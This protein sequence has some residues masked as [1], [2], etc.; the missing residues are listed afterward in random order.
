MNIIVWL[1]FKLTTARTPSQYEFAFY[2]FVQVLYLYTFMFFFHSA[3]SNYVIV[4]IVFFSF[5]I[6]IEM[7]IC[8]PEMQ[9]QI[10]LHGRTLDQTPSSSFFLN[11]ILMH[12][13]NKTQGLAVI[14]L[15]LVRQSNSLLLL[16]NSKFSLSTYLNG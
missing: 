6:L 2:H 16:L 15:N 13:K 1:E 11:G 8:S 7:F 12:S 14:E 5:S 3:Y 9:N 10:I 4:W